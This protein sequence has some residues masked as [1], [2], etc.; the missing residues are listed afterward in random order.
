MCQ[1]YV[2]LRSGK[3]GSCL[4]THNVQSSSFPAR[5]F[6]YAIVMV[7]RSYPLSLLTSI[8]GERVSK[9]PLMSLFCRF[10]HSTGHKDITGQDQDIKGT[11]PYP[12]SAKGSQKGRAWWCKTTE[13]YQQANV[14]DVYCFRHEPSVGISPSSSVPFRASEVPR[15]FLRRR[16]LK[17]RR[18]S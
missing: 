6:S 18:R 12:L 11:L 4:F 17:L 10:Q 3:R 13:H 9:V 2:L 16:I 14:P 1:L 8:A 15:D 7:S 5:E